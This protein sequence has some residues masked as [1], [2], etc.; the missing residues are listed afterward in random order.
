VFVSII[1]QDADTH[2]REG[3][4][5]VMNLQDKRSEGPSVDKKSLHLLK[6]R[7]QRRGLWVI[8]TRECNEATKRRKLKHIVE[9]KDQNSEVLWREKASMRY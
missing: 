5:Q 7:K 3:I 1:F 6:M 8:H 9:S 2:N 4:L